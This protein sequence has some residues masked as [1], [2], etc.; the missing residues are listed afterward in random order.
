MATAILERP[1]LTEPVLTES[2]PTEVESFVPPAPQSIEDTGLPT[3]LF[4]QLI[5]KLLHSRGDMLGRDLS[6]AMGLKFSL[7]EGFIDFFKRQ[8]VIQAKKSLGMGDSTSLFSLSEAGRELARTALEN[9]QYMGPAPV[10]LYQYT[11]IVRRQQ[12][13]AGWLTPEV[14][15]NAYRRMVV[16]PRI[17]SQVGPAVSSGNSFLIYGQPGNGKTFLAEALQNVDDSCIWIPY[18]IECQ[19]AIIQVF[20]PVYHQ[21]VETEERSV[22]AFESPHDRRWV[23]CRRPFIVTGGELGLEMLDL[24]FNENSKVY[25]APH[26]VKANNGIYLIDDFGRQQC[27]PAEILNRWVVPME[28]RIDYLKFRTGGK[29]TVPFETFLIFSTNL[30]PD[31]LGDEAFLRRIRYKMLLRSPGEDEFSSIFRQFC[32]SRAL[33]YE[34]GLIERFLEKHYRNT[35]KVMRRCHPRDVLSHAIDLMH[36]ERLPFLLT[37]DLLDRAFESCFLQEEGD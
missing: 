32:E 8:H 34:G 23:K 5:V 15:A 21:P 28:R 36:F 35:G 1:T 22:L 2:V 6:E 12:R 9:N 16:T 10:P 14:L 7:I 29:M 18:A 25:D 26:Q 30:K 24:N 33:P 17:L 31:Q 19:G 37:D 27:T 4:E 3:S 13:T 11:Y 20:D